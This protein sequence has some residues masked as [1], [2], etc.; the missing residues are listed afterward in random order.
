MAQVYFFKLNLGTKIIHWQSFKG[1]HVQYF[2][3]QTY[4]SQILQY[5]QQPIFRGL[6]KE[7]SVF[8]QF[9]SSYFLS[10]DENILKIVSRNIHKFYSMAS[11]FSQ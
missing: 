9:K 6:I 8:T 2:D 11:N 1:V 4:N 7:C 3:K 5:L 10:F